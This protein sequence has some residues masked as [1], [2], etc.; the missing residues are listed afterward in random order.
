MPHITQVQRYTIDVLKKEGLKQ[1]EIAQRIGK[2]KSVVS[3]ELRRNSDLRNGEYRGDL[4]HRK[5][6]K[7][8]QE[9][10]KRINFTESIKL[11]VESKLEQYYSPE[12]IVGES[13]LLGVK[14]VSVERIYRSGEPSTYLER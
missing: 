10:P 2:D 5:S 9:K 11:C 4:A 6:E 3:R 8:K 14:C 1:G 7:R 12:Q 13:H